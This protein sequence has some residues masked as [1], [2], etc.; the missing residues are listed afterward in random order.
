MQKVSHLLKNKRGQSLFTL[1]ALTVGLL[2][3]SCSNFRGIEGFR[4]PNSCNSGGDNF[5]QDNKLVLPKFW[6]NIYTFKPSR[7]DRG[8]SSSDEQPFVLDWP[9]HMVR[10][11]Q[12][13]RP[14]HNPNHEGIDLAGKINTPVLASH[15]GI[16][17]YAGQGF[18]GYGRMILLQY[19]KTWATLYAHL[20]GYKVKTGYRVKRG[21]LIGF[22]GQSGRV[23]GA[24]LHFELIKEK[25][26]IDPLSMLPW[27]AKVA[28][29][30]AVKRG[31][32]IDE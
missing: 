2:Q 9:V 21:Q 16:V 23:S 6:T 30:Q 28:L 4:M 17:I 18:R 25:Q 10:L 14:P 19:N 15:K 27:K 7:E 20:N 8:N 1:L 11:T 32:Y 3:L 24:H 29:N 31:S 13:F 12:K 5:T 26:P 22:I